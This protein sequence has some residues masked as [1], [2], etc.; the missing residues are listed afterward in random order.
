MSNIVIITTV[1]TIRILFSSLEL[2]WQEQLRT[3][4]THFMLSY[5]LATLESGRGRLDWPLC[6]LT[7]IHLENLPVQLYSW[8]LLADREVVCM[9]NPCYLICTDSLLLH[10]TFWLITSYYPHY[11]CSYHEGGSTCNGKERAW[12]WLSG[13][14][15]QALSN[16]FV[17]KIIFLI[18]R[19]HFSLSVQTLYKEAKWYIWSI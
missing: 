11:H 7:W 9:K 17:F 6:K 18:C 4:V 8:A 19:G 1:V 15:I 12:G 13:D 3:W 2:G 14:L 16:S 5:L 10:E